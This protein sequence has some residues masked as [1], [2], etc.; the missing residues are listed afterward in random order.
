MILD[1]AECD[2]ARLARDPSYDG[3]FF[4]GVS[5]TG[6]YC[7]PVCRLENRYLRTDASCPLLL[8]RNSLNFGLVFVVGLKPPR[9]LHR[10]RRGFADRFSQRRGACPGGRNVRRT[11][12]SGAQTVRRERGEVAPDRAARRAQYR[13]CAWRANS[14]AGCLDLKASCPPAVRLCHLNNKATSGKKDTQSGDHT[15]PSHLISKAV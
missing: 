7:R 1:V 13:G 3:R 2:G 6:V 15:R 14:G 11:K 9:D 4:T 10:D 8:R 12:G 5:I